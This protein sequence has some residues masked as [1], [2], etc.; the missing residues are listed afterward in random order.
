[1]ITKEEFLKKLESVND[2]AIL[3]DMM[4]IIDFYNNEE[5]TI[6]FSKEEKNEI[7][8]SIDQIN[9]GEYKLHQDVMAMTD[10]WLKK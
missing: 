9:R 7:N 1:M 8:N 3:M 10:Q 6:V 4:Q 5:Q 2:P